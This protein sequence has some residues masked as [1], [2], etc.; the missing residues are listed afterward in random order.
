[1]SNTDVARIKVS[2]IETLVKDIAKEKPEGFTLPADEQDALRE[3][4]A[5]KAVRSQELVFLD[6]IIKRLRETYDEN[7]SLSHIKAITL[8][9]AC[10]AD[11]ICSV[12]QVLRNMAN[13]KGVG[14]YCFGAT[15]R[16]LFWHECTELRSSLPRDV[17]YGKK[18]EKALTG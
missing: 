5:A 14:I 12:S 7:T 18:P 1:M 17:L 4:K 16:P 11:D 13:E 2:M 8:V 3:L 15:A 10:N 9:V 6:G